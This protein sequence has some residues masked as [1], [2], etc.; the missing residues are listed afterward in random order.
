MLR[1]TD[2]AQNTNFWIKKA[3]RQVLRCGSVRNF[4]VGFLQS[5][6]LSP[7]WMNAMSLLSMIAFQI[8]QEIDLFDLMKIYVLGGGGH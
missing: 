4:V 6:N 7:F 1:F 8:S 5:I 3:L 2:I